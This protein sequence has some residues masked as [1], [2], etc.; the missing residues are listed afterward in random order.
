MDGDADDSGDDVDDDDSDDYVVAPI[1]LGE[2]GDLSLVK[3]CSV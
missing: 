2:D 3:S 1:V